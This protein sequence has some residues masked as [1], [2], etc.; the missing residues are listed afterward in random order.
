MPPIKATGVA[1]IKGQGVAITK[2]ARTESILPVKR[3]VTPAIPR[4]KS[5]KYAVFAL[6]I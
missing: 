3:K 6:P 2:T 1:R 5:K 4:L